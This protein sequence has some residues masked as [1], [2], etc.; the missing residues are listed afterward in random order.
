[1]NMKKGKT[2]MYKKTIPNRGLSWEKVVVCI[3]I[4][5]LSPSFFDQLAV[6]LKVLLAEIGQQTLPFTD[7]LHQAT[8]SRKILF[9]GLQVFRNTVDPLRQ[10]GDLAL[11][12]TPY[13]QFSHQNP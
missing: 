4:Y 2:F 5:F 1:M 8:M 12:R 3:M 9:V 7:Q 13:W 6:P 11:C 10:Q